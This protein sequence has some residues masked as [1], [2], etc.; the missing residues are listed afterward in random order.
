MDRIVIQLDPRSDFQIWISFSQ[1]I[2]FI[3][4]N[5]G[6]VTIVISESDVG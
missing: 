5:S 2:D 4:I 3:K 6:V 1:P